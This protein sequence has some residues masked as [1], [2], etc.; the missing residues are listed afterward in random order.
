[1]QASF[2]SSSLALSVN[3]N[4]T[5]QAARPTRKRIRHECPSPEVKDGVPKDRPNG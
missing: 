1:M 5:C 2:Q 3:S 4:Y